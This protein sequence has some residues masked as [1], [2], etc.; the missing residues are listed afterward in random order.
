MWAFNTLDG[1]I[2]DRVGTSHAIAA[3][4]Y[5]VNAQPNATNGHLDLAAVAGPRGDAPCHL[6]EHVLG[7]LDALHRG[8]IEI[9]LEDIGR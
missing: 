6:P 5:M 8:R 4:S 1:N 9:G 3:S 2:L 7:M